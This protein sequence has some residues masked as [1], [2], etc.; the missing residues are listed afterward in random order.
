MFVLAND[1][2]LL[3]RADESH[4]EKD[5]TE[6]MA[7]DRWMIHG[8]CRYVLPVEV[9]LIENRKSIPLDKNEGIYVRDTKTGSVRSE[10]GTT[11][12]LKAH[13][14]LWEMELD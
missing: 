3:L 14:E 8:P 10:Q 13:E 1:E 7:G 6:R 5:N 11:Y 2:A 12:M 9:Y 4:K